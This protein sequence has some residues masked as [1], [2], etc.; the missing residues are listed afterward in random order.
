MGT[1][2]AID[3]PRHGE[4][5]RLD[6]GRSVLGRHPDCDIVIEV[7]AVSRHHAQILQIDDR[8]YLEDLGSRNGTYLNRDEV[9]SRATLANGDT[10]R[11]CDVSFRFH[12]VTAEGV[13]SGEPG[14]E[15]SSIAAVLVDDEARSAGP[16]ITSSLAASGQI[17]LGETVTGAEVKLRALLEITRNL[18]KV[19]SLDEVLPKVLDALFAIFTQADRGFIVLREPGG[20]LAPRWAKLRSE[21]SEE[22]LHISR[23]IV[24]RVLDTQEAI[25]SSDAA[26]DSRFDMSQ[27]V[28]DFRIRSMMCAPL[29]DGDGDAFGVLQIDTL[30]QRNRF[31]QEDL[32]VLAS[33]ASQA[34]VAIDNARLHEAALRQ[35]ELQRDLELA[36]EVQRGFLPERPPSVEGFDFFDYYRAANRVGGDYF[37]YIA[38]PNEQVA[39]VVADVVGHG[40]AAALLMAKLS[41][42]TRFSLALESRPGKAMAR[43]NEM[44]GE[45]NF[46]GRFV[47]M[48]LAVLDPKSGEV[49]IANAGHP[50][51]LLRRTDGK[52]EELSARVSGLPL[53]IVSDVEYGE[54][55][56]R[57]AP[58]ESIT[59]YTDGISEAM[60]ATGHM[61][62]T[63]RIRER[64][65]ASE[66]GPRTAGNALIAG[67]RTF[68]GREPQ[69]DD[70]CL[71]C[72][73]RK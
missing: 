58:G 13:L 68:V 38:L 55:I 63:Q 44:F 1:L 65:A 32:D 22:G 57:L 25:L 4:R 35:R 39:I 51:P 36:N 42:E 16:V 67:V 73:G 18:G 71:V 2:L 59:I 26:T 33:V 52:V 23:T 40:V 47:T 53:G 6:Q 28:A 62:G 12:T 56:A 45:E 64:V 17:D 49:A 15:G 43:L 30:D 54:S 31:R 14:G 61:Y 50:R 29:I 11:V 20:M 72:F 24:S 69:A 3:G 10:I 46:D 5:Y 66:D 27:S 41:A 34:A 7:G 37:D 21:D 19:L 48:V 70:M 9:T 60:D 8:Y